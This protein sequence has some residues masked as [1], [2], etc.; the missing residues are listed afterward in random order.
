[1][2]LPDLK[3]LE[4]LGAEVAVMDGPRSAGV[5]LEQARSAGLVLEA[6]GATRCEHWRRS[7]SSTA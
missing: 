3:L 1:M 5:L 7:S 2:P 4:R 6:L